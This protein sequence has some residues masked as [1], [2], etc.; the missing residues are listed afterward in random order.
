M[1]VKAVDASALAAVLFGEPAA[2]TIEARLRDAVLVA[3]RLI[4]YE[5]GNTCWKKC[6]RYPELSDALRESFA[7]L[8]DLP[9]QLHDVDAGA[10]LGVAQALGLTYYDASYLWLARQLRVELVSLDERLMSAAAS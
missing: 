2:E 10:V 5:L 7:S 6:R 8:E 1:A 4:E 3:P 9:L